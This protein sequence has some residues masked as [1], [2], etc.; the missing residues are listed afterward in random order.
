VTAV[1]SAAVTHDLAIRLI[2]LFVPPMISVTASVEFAHPVCKPHTWSV[3]AYWPWLIPSVTQ[4]SQ[5]KDGSDET[6]VASRGPRMFGE[7]RLPDPFADGEPTVQH[8]WPGPRARAI[9]SRGC[10]QPAIIT[11][12]RALH[13][14]ELQS[15]NGTV[16]S[17]ESG[18]RLS[19]LHS[20]RTAR[21]LSEC[22]VDD[23][24]LNF[25]G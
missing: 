15:A 12:L 17:A 21:F 9:R 22:A 16:R 19:V 25:A 13:P 1:T 5:Q 3:S 23:R 2:F 14:Q 18:L 7:C 6:C 20:T 24:L 4:T 8:V 10:L 11:G